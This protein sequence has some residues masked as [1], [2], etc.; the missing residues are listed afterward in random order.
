[1]PAT[2]TNRYLPLPVSVVMPVCNEADVIESVLAEWDF[3]VMSHLP[4][5]SEML[6]DD[7]ASDDG[8]LA[9]LK[10][11]QK[12]YSYLRVLRSQREGFGAA[13]RRLYAEARCPLVFF[14][15]SDGQYVPEDF[16][17]VAA[18]YGR[19]DMIHGYKVG[20]QDSVIRLLASQAFNGLA[21]HA[22]RVPY[23]DIN[24]AFRLVSH[25]LVM[26]QLPRMHCMKTLFNAELLLRL[27]A[28]GYKIQE[29]GVR[30]RPRQFGTSRGLAPHKFLTECHKAYGGLR[31]LRRELR[32]GVHDR[33]A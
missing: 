15:D 22:L 27:S 13:A 12:K 26:S 29:V 17:R 7:G 28:A 14:T 5:G 4:T 31:Q 9:I 6:L 11:Q 20:R 3:A 25:D 23:R 19:A 18:L 10:A 2:I 33:A 32:N 30:H 21:R 1:M 24:S 16:W 8:T